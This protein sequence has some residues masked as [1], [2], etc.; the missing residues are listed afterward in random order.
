MR[1][2]RDLERLAYEF[3]SKI[4]KYINKKSVDEVDVKNA[5]LSLIIQI[6]FRG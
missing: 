5:L 6:I 4:D 1:I 2:D 3:Y